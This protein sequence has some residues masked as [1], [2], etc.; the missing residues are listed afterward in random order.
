MDFRRSTAVLAV[1]LTLA[2]PA[3]AQESAPSAAAAAKESLE[4]ADQLQK[5][6]A[7]WRAAIGKEGIPDPA[8]LAELQKTLES[9]SGEVRL[10]TRMS[11]GARQNAAK[12][13]KQWV[14][15]L[16]SI[17]SGAD[18]QRT[19][20]LGEIRD[21]LKGADPQRRV[22]ALRALSQTGDVKFD[23]A[24]L[25]ERLLE[26]TGEARGAELL[27]ALYAL[28]NVDRQPSD[29]KVVQ[30]AYVRD[31]DALKSS[32]SHLLHMSSDKGRIEG[33]SERIIMGLLKSDDRNV[34]REVLRGLWGAR[35]SDALAAR[36]V[37]L[38]SDQASHHDAIY[39][40]VSTLS[41][42]NEAVIACLIETLSD[43]DWV[44]NGGRA[45]WGLGFGIPDSLKLKVAGA[46][47]E[48]HNQRTDPRIR[49]A[50]QKLVA[51]YGGESMTA[52][53]ERD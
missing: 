24:G 12:L 32:I 25:R 45:L 6:V 42:K 35:V 36:L 49:D 26:L 53:L 16:R 27:A 30:D 41:E 8:A 51:K 1:Q 10:L 4:A 3:Y 11:A 38:V 2:I 20:A 33:E 18:R 43:P 48:L 14:N 47:V 29:L 52:K 34:R 46:L 5:K 15:D 23:R 31:P 9:A 17:G 13:E 28:A 39:F 19:Q 7:E 37:E 44:N 40:G 50:C 22:A 21:A